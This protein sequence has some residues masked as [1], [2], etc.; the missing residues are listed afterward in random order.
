MSSI[1]KLGKNFG[2]LT[3]GNFSS[4]LLSFLFVPLYTAVLSTE[5]YGLVDLLT[6]TISLSFPILTLVISESVMR[7]CLEK[8]NNGKQIF[9]IGFYITTAGC[10]LMLLLSGILFLTPLKDVY[11]YFI[12]H[13]VFQAFYTAIAQYVKGQE[14]IQ[15]YAIGGLLNTASVIGCNLL[16]LLVFKIGIHGY[17]LSMIIGHAVAILF[18][19]IITKSWTCLIPVSKLDRRLLAAMLMYSCPMILNSVSWWISN[20]S[21]KYILSF[22][23][24]LDENGIYAVAYKIPSVLSIVTGLF[25][26]AWQISAVEDFNSEASVNTFRNVGSRYIAVNTIIAGGLITFSRFLAKFLFSADYYIAWK[27]SPVLIL[28]YVF[29]TLSSFYGTIYTSAKKTKMLLYSTLLA[30]GSNIVLNLILIPRWGGMG[31]AIA[32]MVSYAMIYGIRVID[33][34][35][36]MRLHMPWG[37][38]FTGFAL[39]LAEVVLLNLDMWQTDAL[40]ALCTGAILF[41]NLDVCKEMLSVATKKLGLQRSK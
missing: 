16:F 18:Y 26:S 28:A 7:F 24:G 27:I 39:L 21:D 36:I 1:K 25:I 14:K 32:T 12:L 29:N 8:E 22:F 4:S 15:A 30:A 10:L 41:L 38:I 34:A 20:S 5:E 3:I 35:K 19:L 11:W 17:L 31:A 2:L 37:K 9:S 23:H 6:V 40:C 33:S 13:F